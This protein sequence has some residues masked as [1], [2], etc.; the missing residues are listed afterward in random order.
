MPRLDRSNNI[1][2]SLATCGFSW[3][4]G[5]GPSWLPPPFPLLVLTI[6]SPP[7]LSRWAGSQKLHGDPLKETFWGTQLA[8]ESKQL[9]L[10]KICFKFRCLFLFF[11]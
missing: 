11:Y 5:S 3:P 4:H 1:L 9:Q 10:V 7:L 6:P 2:R 8:L